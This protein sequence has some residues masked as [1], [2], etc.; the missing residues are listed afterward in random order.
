[1]FRREAGRTKPLALSL[2]KGGFKRLT[3]AFVTRPFDRLRA[4]GAGVA[5][6]L[7][8][9]AAPA[10]TAPA[11]IEQSRTLLAKGDF[12]GAVA[13]SDRAVALYPRDA[14]ALL[15]AGNL[16]RD[17]Y[18]LSAA[19]PW[20]D[21]VRA[22]APRKVNALIDQAATLGDAA[23]TIAML[24]VT[25]DI[26][27]IDPKNAMVPFLQAVLAARAGKWDVARAAYY[28]T[29]GQLDTVPAV[30]LLRG[31]I[32]V[33][34]GANESAVAA[35]Q[36]LVDAQPRNRHAR[37]LLALALWRSGDAQAT[38]DVLKPISDDGDAWAQLLMARACETVGDRLG[39]AIL[40]DRAATQ[41]ARRP[42]ATLDVASATQAANVRF[43]V[44]AAFRLIDALNRSGDTKAGEAVLATLITQYPASLPAL[45]LAA[46]DALARRE[47]GRAATALE[48]VRV[49]SGDGDAQL[50][51]D[52]G[53]AWFNLGRRTEARDLGGRA[54]ALAPGN[55]A[56]AA[57][58]GWFRTQTGDR[59]GGIALL[60]KAVTIAPIYAPFRAK[61]AEA[62][63]DR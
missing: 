34:T 19:L 55:A 51:A 24:D 50:L 47:W 5:A 57:S 18:G 42:S 38:I 1:M 21:R 59:A 45:R 53:W 31:A 17:R 15:L 16:V 2:S 58:Y 63:R 41:S 54:Y 60:Q 26:T 23:H 7:M 49:R 52:L 32:G 3:V 40:L 30:Q 43:T 4:S 25:R 28:R 44:P 27:D 61:L 56:F 48:L 8:L 6:L 12:A 13:V 20:Y 29:R 37:R 33:Q 10:P 62:M 9:G 11:L 46:S 36:P 39:A 35:L 22:T 14:D